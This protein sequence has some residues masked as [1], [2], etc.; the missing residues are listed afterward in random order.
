MAGESA[1]A[2]SVVGWA[3]S[4]AVGSAG[5]AAWATAAAEATVAAGLVGSVAEGWEAA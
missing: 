5:W 2:G 1:A 3:D 4:V